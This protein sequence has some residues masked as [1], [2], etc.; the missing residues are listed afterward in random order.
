MI[1]ANEE[2]HILHIRRPDL[3]VWEYPILVVFPKR[4]TELTIATRSRQTMS[5]TEACLEYYF[6]SRTTVAH[7]EGAY[8]ARMHLL[9]LGK[10]YQRASFAL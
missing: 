1:S 8:E 4:N 5:V 9:R 3:A 2:I 10:W 7:P 6:S